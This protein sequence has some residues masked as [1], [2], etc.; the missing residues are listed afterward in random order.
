MDSLESLWNVIKQRQTENTEGS[1]TCYLFSKGTDKICKKCGE[2]CTETVIAAKNKDKNELINEI[3][4]LTF[5]VMV[6]MANEGIELS[7]VSDELARRAEKQRNLKTFH[8]V[9]KNT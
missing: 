1:Y 7:Q 8:N 5:H 4:D 9:D 6:L 3:S 2:E